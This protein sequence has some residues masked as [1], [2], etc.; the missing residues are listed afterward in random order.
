MIFHFIRFFTFYN[1]HISYQKKKKKLHQNFLDNFKE[2]FLIL[3]LRGWWPWYWAIKLCTKY[4]RY[5]IVSGSF[6]FE[7]PTCTNR[8]T[9]RLLES[10]CGICAKKTFYQL[11]MLWIS[12]EVCHFKMTK[13]FMLHGSPKSLF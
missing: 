5:N 11:C 3:K 1:I 9:S 12:Y 7:E 2:N 6:L 13:R 10:T 4:C 8:L